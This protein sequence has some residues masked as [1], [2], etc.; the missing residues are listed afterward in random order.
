MKNGVQCISLTARQRFL[1]FENSVCG[2]LRFYND[3]E[4]V[5]KRDV[6]RPYPR[7]Q[8]SLSILNHYKRSIYTTQ[9]LSWESFS[10]CWVV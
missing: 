6:Y 2:V 4:Y 10:N 8:E 1:V 7:I 5:F 3:N 9:K